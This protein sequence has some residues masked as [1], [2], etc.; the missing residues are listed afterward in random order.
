MLK[1]KIYT[2][3]KMFFFW[4]TWLISSLAAVA[5]LWWPEYAT[6]I[7][8]SFLAATTL[9]LM[10]LSIEFHRSVAFSILF[11]LIALIL[12]VV[13]IEQKSPFVGHF[14]AWVFSQKLEASADFYFALF[15]AMSLN[16]IL[17]FFGTRLDYWTLTPN[18]IVH[19]R[20]FLGGAERYTT[21][22]VKVAKEIPDIFEYLMAGSGTLVFTIPNESTPIIL[23]NVLSIKQVEAAIQQL[24]AAPKVRID[25]TNA[26]VVTYPPLENNQYA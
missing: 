10:I 24:I 13:L 1:I 14:A 20:G 11:L 16:F 26:R 23:Y 22:G 9:N 19:R 8:L 7:A 12:A 4:P 6:V 5:M 15:A 2:W 21:S 17:M 3:P 25:D 18:E